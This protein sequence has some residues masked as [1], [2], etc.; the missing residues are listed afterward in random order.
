MSHTDSTSAPDD[1]STEV[2]ALLACPSIRVS[3]LAPSGDYIIVI[4]SEH[5]AEA[6]TEAESRASGWRGEGEGSTYVISI[7]SYATPDD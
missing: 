6:L 7:D 5:A 1:T 4:P 2:T 3:E